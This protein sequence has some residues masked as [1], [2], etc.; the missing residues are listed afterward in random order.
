MTLKELREKAGKIFERMK[1][2]RDRSNDEKHTWTDSDES[3]WKKVNDEYESTARLIER[4]KR[5]DEIEKNLSASADEERRDPRDRGDRRGSNKPG[6]DDFDGRNDP[7]DRDPDR[8]PVTDEERAEA[9]QGWCLRQA[10]ENLSKSQRRACERSRLDPR[11]KRVTLNLATTES[12]KRLQRTWRS[13]H[14]EEARAK[15]EREIERR[16]G[17]LTAS[18]GSGGYFVPSTLMSSLELAMLEFGPMLQVA[19][20]IR[21]TTGEP[22]QWPMADDTSN[23]G[24]L[25]AEQ[26]S[27]VN[28]VDPSMKQ[29]M[30]LAYKYKSG[31]IRVSYELLTDSVINLVQVLAEMIGERLGRKLN[32]EFTV[33]TGASC[34]WGIVEQA[35]TGVTAASATAIAADEFFDLVHSVDPAYRNGAGFM[36]HDNVTLAARKLKS[37]SGEYLWQPGLS[38]GKPD[39]LLGYTHTTNQHM[40]SSIASGAKTVLFGQ[41]SKYKVRMDA[42]VRFRRLDEL[43]AGTD[44]VAFLGLLRADGKLMDAGTHPVKRLVQA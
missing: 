19:D 37:G 1:V 22:L 21:T 18:G 20:V 5:V 14:A 15:C 32:R 43:Y 6:R 26:G 8:K 7:A 36:M 16:A 29:F 24:S 30:L 33:G 28:Q 39:R 10:G 4:A 2:L 23:E 35:T 17:L 38:E 11:S 25:I 13:A 9:L 12:Y 3:D 42:S 34:P 44:E 41:F 40:A 27:V 31:A